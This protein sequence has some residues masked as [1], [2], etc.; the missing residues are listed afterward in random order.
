MVTLVGFVDGVPASVAAVAA[1]IVKRSGL[2]GMRVKTPNETKMSC[3]ERGA[4]AVAGE[5]VEVM[6][7]K[8]VRLLA[9]SSGL[10]LA[11]LHLDHIQGNPALCVPVD[12][13]VKV[14]LSWPFEMKSKV[15]PDVNM[16]LRL[17]ILDS[18]IEIV[19]D[20]RQDWPHVGIA[21]MHLQRMATLLADVEAKLA[22]D[23]AQRMVAREVVSPDRVERAQEI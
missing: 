9:A 2:T 8:V 1:K 13:E 18:D 3:C 21:E 6:E 19:P 14:V 4:R 11:F 5:R 23:G 20:R 17:L 22:R 10:V 7:N 15:L 12:L 16:H